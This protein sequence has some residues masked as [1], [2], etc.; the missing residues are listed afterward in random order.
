M[1]TDNKKMEIGKKP[2]KMSGP[3][4]EIYAETGRR[5]SE[6]IQRQNEL[7]AYTASGDNNPKIMAQLKSRL[8]ETEQAIVKGNSDIAALQASRGGRRT[9]GPSP[10]QMK[11]L[12][13][14]NA[15]QQ[16]QVEAQMAQIQKRYDVLMVQGKMEQK[17]YGQI[18]PDTYDELTALLERQ[19]ELTGIYAGPRKDTPYIP[20]IVAYKR[21]AATAHQS[22]NGP[23]HETH[24]EAEQSRGGGGGGVLGG[25]VLDGVLLSSSAAASSTALAPPHPLGIL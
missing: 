15:D 23:E 18:R 21:A 4:A 12:Q 6:L 5:E 25:G 20:P 1:L 9:I 2:P 11:K 22:V 14:A 19:E 10:G 24:V 16:S 3:G 17:K 13:E 8:Q 7:N